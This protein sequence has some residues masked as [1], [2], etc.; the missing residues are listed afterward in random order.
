[1]NAREQ[2]SPSTYLF[3][4]YDAPPAAPHSETTNRRPSR[5]LTSP[6]RSATFTGLPPPQHP[7]SRSGF[8]SFLRRPNQE[9]EDRN[10][11]FNQSV[12]DGDSQVIH[13]D[14]DNDADNMARPS[15]SRPTGNHVDLTQSPG[16]STTQQSRTRK[17]S[18][19]SDGGASGSANKRARRSSALAKAV[20]VGDDEVFE[21]EAPSA[22][23]ELLRDQQAEAL[24]MQESNKEEV[25][26]K[27]GKRNCIICLENY[28]NATT[29]ICGKHNGS[30][31]HRCIAMLTTDPRPHLLPRVSH[32]RPHGFGEEQRSRQG[33]L[34]GVQESHQSEK[35]QR[36]DPDQLHEEEC[37]QD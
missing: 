29:A 31:V 17:R 4:Q 18:S 19:T 23:A 32:A 8:E 1:M 16:N 37:F 30:G 9:E 21:D 14:S 12:L 20:V 10:T 13:S 33:K 28:T 35:R 7:P 24:K 34:P 25:A 5:D 26:V 22:E 36:G 11:S 3:P 15:R 6:Y 27:I 2:Q